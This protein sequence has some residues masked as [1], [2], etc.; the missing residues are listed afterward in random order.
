ME[1]VETEIS[2]NDSMIGRDYYGIGASGAEAVTNTVTASHLTEVKRVLDLPCGHGR[3][4]RHIVQLFPDAQFDACDL[5][6]DGVRFYAETFGARPIFSQPNLTEVRFD[7]RYDVIWI[8]SLFTHTSYEITKQWLMFLAGLISDKGIIVATFHGRF[9]PRLQRVLSSDA[10]W[11][12]IYEQ[13]ESTGY[14]YQDYGP[15]QG[16]DFIQGSYGVSLAK[17]ATII[18]LVQ[19]IPDTRIFKYTERGWARN[20]DVVAFGK[21]GI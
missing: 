1:K 19:Q 13:Y 5:D 8:G 20:H 14:G 15:R 16:H 12:K 9:T 17:A 7:S 6:A 3:V 2:E 11:A 21:P 10:R 4:L 18:D